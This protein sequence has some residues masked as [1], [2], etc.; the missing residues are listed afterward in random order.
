MK[1]LYSF[2]FFVFLARSHIEFINATH[3]NLFVGHFCYSYIFKDTGGCKLE[4][5]MI[6][7]CPWA[8]NRLKS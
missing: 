7:D 2:L 5:K 8:K 3:E 1:R 4:R 6:E